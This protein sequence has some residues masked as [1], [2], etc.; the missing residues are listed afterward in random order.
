MADILWYRSLYWRI[1]LGFVLLLAA[2]L[3]V[4]GGA[5]LWLT[6]RADAFLTGRSPAE[7][8]TSIASDLSRA[9]TA[10]PT[11]DID[12]Y[13]NR[14]YPNT[15]RPFAVVM[16]DG[17]SI[18]SRGIPPP[19]NIDRLARG[20]LAGVWSGRGRGWPWRPAGGRGRG[21]GPRP[22]FE[23]AQISVNG[24]VVGAVA[25]S[26]APPP[27]YLTLRRFGPTLAGV[28]LLLLMAGTAVAALLVFRPAHRRLRSLQLAAAELGAGHT[29][30]R[31]PAEGGDEVTALAETFNQMAIDL[32]ERARALASAD[33]ARRQ[34]LADVSHELTTP[35][36]AIRGY[37]ETLAMPG[38]ALD[39]M[40]RARYLRI[41]GEET[42][43][44]DQIVGDLLDLARLEGGGTSM[45]REPVSVEHLFERVRH[46]HAPGV[47]EKSIVLETAVGPDALTLRG[48]ANRLEQ[49]LQNLVA[50]AVRHT[51]SGGTIRVSS[52]RVPGGIQLLVEDTGPGIPPEHLPRLFDRFY[53]VDESRTGTEMPSGSGLGLSIVQAIVRRHGGEVV[54]SN[55]S[56]SGARFEITLPA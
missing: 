43:R 17:R 13:V 35:L 32:E 23:L 52:N 45:K 25:V 11:L 46:R 40:T 55:L 26:S 7:L 12:S 1:A 22:L 29:G 4:Q 31:A 50:N 18:L 47:R 48:D 15:F 27:I 5:F 41:V 30:A 49:A 44:L 34:L 10:Q 51:P 42:E 56:P 53:K 14:R 8:S 39:S 54:A 24:A 37:V 36:A 6:G 3:A 19:P 16:K 33:L 20:Q 28:A 9:L 38:V 2:L 21:G